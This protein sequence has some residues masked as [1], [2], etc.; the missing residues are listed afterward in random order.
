MGGIRL[1]YSVW[2]CSNNRMLS[3][4]YYWVYFTEIIISAYPHFSNHRATHHEQGCSYRH[5]LTSVLLDSALLLKSFYVFLMLV[6]NFDQFSRTVSLYTSETSY[7]FKCGN[8][9]SWGSKDLPLM[10]V[11]KIITLPTPFSPNKLSGWANFL[12]GCRFKTAKKK[13]IF[14]SLQLHSKCTWMESIHVL[15]QAA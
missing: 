12:T 13:M 7:L 2:G 6:T 15:L 9:Q 10:K 3:V 11:K 8:P 4:C 5:L 14:M 1:L